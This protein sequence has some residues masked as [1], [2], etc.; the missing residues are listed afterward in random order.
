MTPW[1]AA[2]QAPLSVNSP[3][4]NTGMDCHSL[5]QGIFPTQRS[6]WGLLHCRWTL[7]HLCH[8]ESIF[9]NKTMCSFKILIFRRKKRKKL[10]KESKGEE[11]RWLLGLPAW[12]WWARLF[13]SC[14]SATGE[15]T[16]GHLMENGSMIRMLLSWSFPWSPCHLQCPAF[17]PA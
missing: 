6:N 2:H 5:L 12:G 4:K 1:T 3:G 11:M 14:E 10:V 16:A 15:A 7:Y 9:R 17:P 8:Q 13:I